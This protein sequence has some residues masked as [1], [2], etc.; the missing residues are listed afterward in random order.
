MDHF[1]RVVESS[2]GTASVAVVMVAAAVFS[3]ILALLRPVLFFLKNKGPG[4]VNVTFRVG[5]GQPVQQ[6]SPQQQAEVLQGLNTIERGVSMATVILFSAIMAVASGAMVYLYLQ[7]PNDGHRQSRIMLF[8]F[9]YAVVM[10]WALSRLFSGVRPVDP[11]LSNAPGLA[12]G[13]LE[14]ARQHIDQGGTV[15]EACA[16]VNPEYGS[17]TPTM[18]QLFKKAIERYRLTRG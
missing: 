14:R 17:M 4:E 15:E 16:L 3:V 8:G 1:F 7:T 13:W 10:M 9:G 5:A 12:D 11:P 18:Q 2:L 6:A